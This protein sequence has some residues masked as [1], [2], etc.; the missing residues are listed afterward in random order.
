[1]LK[2]RKRQIEEEIRQVKANIHLNRSETDYVLQLEDGVKKKYILSK[3]E[4][5]KEA[6]KQVESQLKN[7]EMVCVLFGLGLGHILEALSALTEDKGIIILIEPNRDLLEQAFSLRHLEDLLTKSNVR[8]HIGMEEESL[9]QLLSENIGLIDRENTLVL[10]PMGYEAFYPESYKEV[11]SMT[12]EVLKALE[13]T[14]NTIDHFATLHFRNLLK[15]AAYLEGS[16]DLR[17]HFGKYKNIPALIVAGGP[18]LS[19]NIKQAKGFKGVIFAMGR[20]LSALMKEGIRPDFVVAIDPQENAISAYKEGTQNDIPFITSLFTTT[21]VVSRHKGAKYFILPHTAPMLDKVRLGTQ[22][23][24]IDV[25]GTVANAI[26]SV[27]YEMGCDPIV[28]IGQDLAY[29]KGQTHYRGTEEGTK[30]VG[31]EEKAQ[32]VEVEGYQGGKVLSPPNLLGYLRWFESF[33]HTHADRTYINATEGG[34][35]IQ[36]CIPLTLEETLL[37]LIDFSKPRVEESEIKIKTKA[38]TQGDFLKEIQYLQ[39]ICREEKEKCLVLKGQSLDTKTLRLLYQQFH[40]IQQQ[41][42]IMALDEII[43]KHLAKVEQDLTYKEP[44]QETPVETCIRI[45][46]NLQ[47]VFGALEEALEEVIHEVIE[48]KR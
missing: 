47:A 14:Q 13:V 5:A 39:G 2:E 23:P 20:T 19:K 10:T 24:R 3:Y 46:S 7:K 17:Q 44:L 11:Q 42:C 27:A 34:A 31:E 41:E 32:L 16:Y 36:G 22:V 45:S 43:R 8:L 35:K 25:G 4:P 26:V 21:E 1:M 33:I 12:E 48:E 29:T 18:S 6:L 38:G 15:N 9:Y 37:K 28:F 40:F 30:G